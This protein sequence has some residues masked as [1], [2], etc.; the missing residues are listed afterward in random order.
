MEEAVKGGG[1]SQTSGEK[2]R[3]TEEECTAIKEGV[4]MV[5]E[6]QEEMRRRRR[7]NGGH[8]AKLYTRKIPYLVMQLRK[9]KKRK[10]R[11]ESML[12]GMHRF[13]WSFSHDG[14]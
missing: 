13:T 5:C 10:G 8:L 9:V 11:A 7:R 1:G 14:G 12:P 6:F 4:S 2:L 3:P